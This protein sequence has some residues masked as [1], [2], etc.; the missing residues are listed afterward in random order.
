MASV[1][2]LSAETAWTVIDQ[3]LDDFDSL[4]QFSEADMKTLCLT[5]C[6]PGGM[7][8]NLRANIADQP[9]TIRDSSHLISVVAEKR[10]LVT[11]YATMNQARTS[12][13]IDSQSMCCSS[14]DG[15]IYLVDINGTC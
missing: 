15:T 6:R 2:N 7:R 11:S 13:P 5:F 9:P 8:I 14:L 3:R 12:R 10:L 4:V 1:I